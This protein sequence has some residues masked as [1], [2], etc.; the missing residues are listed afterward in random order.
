MYRNEFYSL[1][2]NLTFYER[3]MNKNIDTEIKHQGYMR[4]F[5]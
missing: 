4:L 1:Y 5:W 2:N 3:V